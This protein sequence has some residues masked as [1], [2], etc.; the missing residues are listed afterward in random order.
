ME[1]KRKT[2]RLEEDIEFKIEFKNYLRTT[3]INDDI[4]AELMSELIQYILKDKKIYVEIRGRGSDDI[5]TVVYFKRSEPYEHEIQVR[6][7]DII[8]YMTAINY[9]I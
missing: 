2:V 3:F 9:G 4:I 5:F 7:S 8:D 1:R 6:V